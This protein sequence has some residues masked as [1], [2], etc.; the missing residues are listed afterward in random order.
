Q[1]FAPLGLDHDR[2]PVESPDA[3]FD[4][5]ARDHL[6]GDGARVL[7]ALEEEPVLDVDVRP[8]HAGP[9]LIPSA[10]V[11]AAPRAP[12]CSARRTTPRSSRAGTR[13]PGVSRSGAWRSRSAGT[14]PPRRARR[15]DAAPTARI[16]WPGTPAPPAEPLRTATS[17]P[18]RASRRRT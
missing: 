18:R 15:R 8:V 6:Q 13:S 12:S 11:R 1:D 5:L 17:G 7:Q 14:L 16:R 9:R 10:P 3:S 4:A 2:E